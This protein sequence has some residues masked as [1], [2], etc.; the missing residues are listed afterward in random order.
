MSAGAQ[1]EISILPPLFLPLTPSHTHMALCAWSLSNCCLP[2]ISCSLS[3]YLSLSLALVH[4]LSSS[5]ISSP[6]LLLFSHQI[7]TLAVTSAPHSMS[8]SHTNL[9]STCLEQST[10]CEICI[11]HLAHIEAYHLEIFPCPQDHRHTEQSTEIKLKQM[12]RNQNDK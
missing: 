12:Q 10:V 1:A 4:S 9:K 8:D 5:E 11:M 3:R 7:K 2:S 6:S